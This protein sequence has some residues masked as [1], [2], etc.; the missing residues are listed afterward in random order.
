[1]LLT[2]MKTN[3]G[4]IAVYACVPCAQAVLNEL[5]YKRLCF[6]ILCD[7]TSY[8]PIGDDNGFELPTRQNERLHWNTGDFRLQ[9]SGLGDFSG[10][11]VDVYNFK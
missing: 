6:I 10:T 3:G 4:G 1:M 11:I 5:S 8:L 2:E 9:K 7:H